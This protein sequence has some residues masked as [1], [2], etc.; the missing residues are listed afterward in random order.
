M[1]DSENKN[2]NFIPGTWGQ[3]KSFGLTDVA[4]TTY[5]RHPNKLATLKEMSSVIILTMMEQ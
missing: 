2:Y 5:D 4:A 3:I 1:I